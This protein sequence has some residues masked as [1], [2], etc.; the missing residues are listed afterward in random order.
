M[1]SEIN[2]IQYNTIRRHHI[3]SSITCI[4]HSHYFWKEFL[5]SF[6]PLTDISKLT[7]NY[8]IYSHMQMSP[9]KFTALNIYVALKSWSV[10]I[11]QTWGSSVK[12]S[13]HNSTKTTE[14]RNIYFWGAVSHAAL[15][16]MAMLCCLACLTD[17]ELSSRCTVLANLYN[18]HSQINENLTWRTRSTLGKSSYMMINLCPSFWSILY[19]GSLL[20]LANSH[21]PANWCYTSLEFVSVWSS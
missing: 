14:D 9:F 17:E 15:K 3:T 1:E 13:W 11:M 12:Y 7:Q 18:A 21:C 4:H 8:W 5:H 20:S 10:H 6:C 2:T 16:M 19:C